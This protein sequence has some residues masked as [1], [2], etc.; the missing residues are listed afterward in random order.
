MKSLFIPYRG[1]KTTSFEEEDA[2][3]CFKG[4][5]PCKFILKNYWKSIKFGLRY[6][7]RGAPVVTMAA[8]SRV[9]RLIFFLPLPGIHW[10]KILFW[11][12]IRWKNLRRLEFLM[13]CKSQY[14]PCF[15]GED[16]TT[17]EITRGQLCCQSF[18]HCAEPTVSGKPGESGIP[19]VWYCSQYCNL[20]IFPA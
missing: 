14:A 17:Y 15:P 7:N 19:E 20:W 6:R 10:L 12:Q 3:F 5:W 13:A 8:L 2:G 9:K 1:C 11:K 16:S 4:S 18:C